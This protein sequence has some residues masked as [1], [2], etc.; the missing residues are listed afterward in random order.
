MPASSHHRH[1]EQ[2]S[3]Q[4]TT[5][6]AITITLTTTVAFKSENRVGQTHSTYRPPQYITYGSRY[7]LV[8]YGKY[9]DTGSYRTTLIFFL[10]ERRVIEEASDDVRHD[11]AD[12]HGQLHGHRGGVLKRTRDGFSEVHRPT[13]ERK[14]KPQ[15]IH[16]PAIGR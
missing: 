3:Q 6:D 9:V 1:R 13:P 12:N 2:Q 15:A 7:E 8:T 4:H 11:D 5:D 16:Q 10:T 14:P